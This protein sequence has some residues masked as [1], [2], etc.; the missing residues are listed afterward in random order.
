MRNDN[1]GEKKGKVM[2]AKEEEKEEKIGGEEKISK[3]AGTAAIG[4][5]LLSLARKTL[6][7]LPR[8]WMV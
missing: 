7:N 2:A 4:C 3:M 6:G 8:P 1:E 5:G